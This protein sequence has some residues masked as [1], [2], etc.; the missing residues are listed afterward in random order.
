MARLIFEHD[1]EVV[2]ELSV[3]KAEARMVITHGNSSLPLTSKDELRRVNR[4][5]WNLLSAI[6]Y[7]TRGSRLRWQDI[8]QP[9]NF[10]G[11]MAKLTKEAVAL[12]RHA[13]KQRI[14]ELEKRVRELE[15]LQS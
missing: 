11:V 2:A 8:L 5:L 13:E 4:P 15:G 7:L 10:Q 1:G 12:K 9:F 14:A 3:D 6:C